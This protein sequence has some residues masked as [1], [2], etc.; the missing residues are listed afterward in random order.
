L[1]ARHLEEN[2][3][4]VTLDDTDLGS[5][6]SL[7]DGLMHDSARLDAMSQASRRLARPDAARDI[8][9][10]VLELTEK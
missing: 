5:M 7:V 6:L 10:L 9:R 3:A 1:N 4:A 8:A 2:G